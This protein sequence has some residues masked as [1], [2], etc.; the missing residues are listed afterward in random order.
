M[1]IDNEPRDLIQIQS[2]KTPKTPSKDV[3]RQGASVAAFAAVITCK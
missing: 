3:K 2:I 1:A